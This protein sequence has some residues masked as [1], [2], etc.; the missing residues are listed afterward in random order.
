MANKSKATSKSGKSTHT[1]VS[2]T[3]F[4]PSPNKAN[5]YTYIDTLASYHPDVWKA[6]ESLVN[7]LEGSF[8][9]SAEERLNTAIDFLRTTAA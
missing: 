9:M 2:Y 6:A 3:S 8:T 5:P 4:M 1:P 7:G